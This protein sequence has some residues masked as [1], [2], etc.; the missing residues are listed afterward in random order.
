MPEWKMK[1]KARHYKDG[2]IS[3]CDICGKPG[4]YV[5]VNGAKQLSINETGE[6]AGFCLKNTCFNIALLSDRFKWL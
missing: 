6:I 3:P 5:I 1:D 4:K 2:E